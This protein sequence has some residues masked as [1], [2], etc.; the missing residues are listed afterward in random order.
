LEHWTKLK[1]QFSNQFTADSRKFVAARR[2]RV[3]MR[4]LNKRRMGLMSLPA[5]IRGS[6]W[7]FISTAIS[8][9]LPTRADI[10][11]ISQK[12][13]GGNGTYWAPTDYGQSLGDTPF[14]TT[15]SQT[16]SASGFGSFTAP[17]GVV[18][19]VSNIDTASNQITARGAGDLSPTPSLVMNQYTVYPYSSAHFEAAFRLTDPAPYQVTVLADL[20][21]SNNLKLIGP[22]SQTLTFP[23]APQTYSG[24]LS[25]GDW[26]VLATAAPGGTDGGGPFDFAIALPEPMGLVT[27]ACAALA[28]WSGRGRRSRRI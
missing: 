16:Y 9:A 18:G 27:C 15:P 17:V 20:P 12:R 11:W 26:T 10:T 25:A 4:T 13:Y 7:V 3:M 6:R 2:G 21:G 14:F 19:F 8:P 23:V 5:L 28:V 24:V 22:N 1:D